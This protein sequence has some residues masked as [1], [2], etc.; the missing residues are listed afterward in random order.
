M[1]K[2]FG[3]KA[4]RKMIIL[5]IAVCM[6]VGMSYL[7]NPDA[8]GKFWRVMRILAVVALPKAAA[9]GPV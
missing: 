8:L 3:D 9:L 1:R 2:I 5:S 7:S 6:I 4:G